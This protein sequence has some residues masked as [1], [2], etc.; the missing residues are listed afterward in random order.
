[1][2]T[3]HPLEPDEARIR[4]MIDAVVDHI[5]DVQR[6]LADAPVDT[7]GS[8]NEAFL[9]S[10]IEPL[11]EDGVELRSLLHTVFEHSATN[12]LNTASPG[13]MAYVPGGGIFEAGL[14]DLIS[15]TLN[16]YVGVAVVA[17]A[18]TQLE[19]NVVRWFAEII[20]YPPAARGFLT[21][22]GSLATLS[23]VIT[24]R[25]KQLGEQFLDGTV[26]V[27][28]QA[29]HCVDKAARLAGIPAANLRVVASDENFRL[30][31]G[32]LR[33]AIEADQAAGL[34]PFLLVA[35][36]GTTNSGAVDPMPQLAAL[37]R[38]HGLWFHVDGAYGGFFNLTPR[39]RQVL[40]GIEQADSVVLDP[41]KTLF[42][43]YGTGALLVRDGAALRSTHQ[44]SADYLPAMQDDDAMVDFCE[45]SPELT[46]PFRG[47]RVWLPVKLHGIDVFRRYLDEK[48]DLAQD[49]FQR[50]QALPEI[51]IL[52][53]PELS[54]LAFALRDEGQSLDQRNAATRALMQQIIDKQRVA[55]SGT[56]L[57]GVFA[58]RVA[59]SAHRTHQQ[60]VDMLYQDLLEALG[61]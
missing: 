3:A 35:S 9:K 36:A 23:A 55:L 21:S 5:C 11:P 33:E 44:A 34:R 60:Q 61:Q 49:I 57:N 29:H 45:L 22:G 59:I 7:S 2:H 42:L 4:Q 46:R 30:E 43:P 28:D 50:L 51:E 38:E 48:L 27:S 47:L 56:I 25:H 12:S 15:T 14:A 52:A 10:L 37:A 31:L 26:Y 58:I 18:L 8:A 39:G 19:A 1:M 20:G 6:E 13:F 17:P 54:I 32:A 24:A 40:V 53:P 16:R 41:H